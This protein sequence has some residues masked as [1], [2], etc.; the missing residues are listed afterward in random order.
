[1]LPL[2]PELTGALGAIAISL[3]IGFLFG[4]SLERAGFGDSRKLAAQ[5]YLHDMTVFKVMFTAIVTAMVLLFTLGGLGL[6]DLARIWVNP[7]YLWPG[8]L[9]GLVLG[10]GF[11]IGGYCPGTAV[12]SLATLK[13]DG[14]FF[15]LGVLAGIFAFAETLPLFQGFY[16]HA[17]NFGT[18]TLPDLLGLT[19]GPV[20][21]A[22][23]VMALIAFIGA[24]KVERLALARREAGLPGP[25]PAAALR[26]LPRRGLSLALVGMA[27]LVLFVGRATPQDRLARLE[28]ALDRELAGRAAQ[29]H[30]G[31]LLGL[32][33]NNRLRLLLVDVRP[34]ADYNLFH[35]R[36]A[37]R[38]P[39]AAMTPTWV[40]AVP[41]EAVV[42]LVSNGEPR[43]EA[44][45]KWLRSQGLANVY[46][47]EGGLNRWLEI[48]G[49]GTAT[50]LHPVPGDAEALRFTLPLAAGDHSGP[51]APPADFPGVG[52]F[53][54]KVKALQAVP[55]AGGGCG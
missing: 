38:V 49:A 36:D 45:W 3:A 29:L 19:A 31:E 12:V 27:A 22:V 15:I 55:V 52:G 9:G 17:G 25:I 7:T 11:I 16:H 48:F 50:P 54:A 28:P 14:L 30:P 20:A 33:H 43:A 44:A 24:E 8:I 40:R 51:A 32:M 34:E 35:L 6:V 23:A 10:M 18:I 5:F 47:L 4:F 41:P 2:A 46:L 13:L 21:A 26:L 53:T 1:M 42:V 39:L 37:Q